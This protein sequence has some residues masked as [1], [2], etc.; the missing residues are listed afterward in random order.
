MRPWIWGVSAEC[1]FG[2]GAKRDT[3][4]WVLERNSLELSVCRWF[5][6]C[7]C[8]CYSH[9]MCK[10]VCTRV[11][12]A[13]VFYYFFFST[14]RRRTTTKTT[15][16]GDGDIVSRV[17][18]RRCVCAS[19]FL[20]FQKCF[21]K[22]TWLCYFFFCFSLFLWYIWWW[23]LCVYMLSLYKS[24]SVFVISCRVCVFLRIFRVSTSR[25]RASTGIHNQWRRRLSN[26][27]LNGR[28][29]HYHPSV[30]RWRARA[31]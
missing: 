13:L 18:E 27:C 23:C 6:T 10:S 20:W 30:T 5:N 2:K 31:V 17:K 11:A 16:F 12:C 22:A 1:I 4:F 3:P 28:I 14:T 29:V 15:V 9:C 19:F 26:K 24:E 8:V 7:A 25:A 21:K